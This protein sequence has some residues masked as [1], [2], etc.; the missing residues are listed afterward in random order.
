MPYLLKPTPQL[1]SN[2][3]PKSREVQKKHKLWAWWLSSPRETEM[4]EAA[5]AVHAHTSPSPVSRAV[6][7]GSHRHRKKI[8]CSIG[9]CAS[10]FLRARMNEGAEVVAFLCKSEVE[11]AAAVCCGS[12]RKKKAFHER[13]LSFSLTLSLFVF[14]L[15]NYMLTTKGI[16]F[17]FWYILG[18][19]KLIECYGA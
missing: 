1:S 18:C 17:L 9:C 5:A 19:L 13:A 3:H 14:F 11:Y 16:W 10:R 4:A 6:A 12:C 2:T 8:G 15:V 7:R